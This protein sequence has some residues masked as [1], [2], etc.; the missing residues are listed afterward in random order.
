MFTFATGGTCP[1]FAE[2]DLMNFSESSLSVIVYAK[3]T[4]TGLLA[5]ERLNWAI[6]DRG[7]DPRSLGSGDYIDHWISDDS[8]SWQQHTLTCQRTEDQPLKLR[9]W[10]SRQSGNAYAY[11]YVVGA[12]G[13][14]FGIVG[15]NVI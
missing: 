14:S 4:N 3:N 2:W 13:I 10:G 7:H 11:C 5:T 12:G 8:T 6:V 15:T 9:V 1:V